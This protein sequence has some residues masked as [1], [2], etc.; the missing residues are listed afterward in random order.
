V[1]HVDLA[2]DNQTNRRVFQCHGNGADRFKIF[3][4]IF[5]DH[6]VAPR[7]AAHKPA[8]LILQRNRKA[9]DFGFHAVLG[10]GLCFTHPR[11]KFPQFLIGK[12]ILQTFQRHRMRDLLKLAER[13]SANP[14]CRTDRR[15]KFRILLFQ[16]LQAPHHPVVLEIRQFRIVHHVIQMVCPLQITGQLFDFLFRI[17]IS[18]PPWVFGF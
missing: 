8:V 17:H 14:L 6:A 13:L 3:G 7:G 12:H 2:P 18:L 10:I 11:I 5:P 15:S 1:R 9:I 4:H 16:R